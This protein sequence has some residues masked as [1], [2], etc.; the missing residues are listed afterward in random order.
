MIPVVEFAPAKVNLWL[1]ILGRRADGYHE[2]ESLVAFADDAGDTVSLYPGGGLGVC[3]SGEFAPS[4][5]APNILATALKILREREPRL[6]LGAVA[7]AK[8][9]PVSAGLGGGSA[10]AAALLRAVRRANPAFDS[11]DWQG[12]ALE[13]GSDV[14][15][16]LERRSALVR[17]RGEHVRRVDLPV[18]SAVLV[19]PRASVLDG[20]TRAVFSRLAAAPPVARDNR[21]PA[22]AWGKTDELLR[23]MRE[24]GNDLSAAAFRIMPEIG[25]VLR[26][27]ENSAGCE[28]VR[29]SGAGP[30]CFGVF[31]SPDAA[32]AAAG[33]I[34]GKRPN[35][36]V[37]TARL[38]DGAD[39]PHLA[40]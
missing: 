33:V 5:A 20:K 37:R 39:T 15:V 27:I 19:N 28:L 10:D 3:V 26:A 23:S 22:R 4:P 30:T 13:L 29:M 32:A 24:T 16:C 17:G 1:R 12:V 9:L 25:E 34:G 8:A 6:V 7:L 18:L 35:W 31:G 38:G 14:P 2:I 36:W 11:F 40:P 21:N